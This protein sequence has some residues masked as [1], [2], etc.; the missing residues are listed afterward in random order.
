M[1][2][3][4][5]LE[6]KCSLISVHRGLPEPPPSPFLGVSCDIQIL[7]PIFLKSQETELQSMSSPWGFQL[8]VMDPWLLL[9]PS[10]SSIQPYFQSPPAPPLLPVATCKATGYLC[11]MGTQGC[12]WE[13]A[14]LYLPRLR[15]SIQPPTSGCFV[16]ILGSPWMD[17]I[18]Y[19][20]SFC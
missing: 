5:F 4:S 19:L 1:I 6:Y 20:R 3:K 18:L 7:H 16:I 8:E 17:L 15:P 12:L 13:L 2:F 10:P 11:H 9:A 14:M